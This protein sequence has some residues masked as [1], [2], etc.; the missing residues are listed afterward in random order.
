MRRDSRLTTG[1]YA[2]DEICY[3]S[4]RAVPFLILIRLC[5]DQH[6]P[7]RYWQAPVGCRHDR[8]HQE[9][10]NTRDSYQRVM[11]AM[12]AALV[13]AKSGAWQSSADSS[14]SSVRPTS[15]P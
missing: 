14:P 1:E 13:A 10:T 4:P 12:F 7:P 5:V 9:C 2:L 8:G 15:F 3:A 11:A 6:Q